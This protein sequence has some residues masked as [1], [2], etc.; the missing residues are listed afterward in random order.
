MHFCY[1]AM[2]SFQNYYFEEILLGNPK[3]YGGNYAYPIK[4]LV[5]TGLIP[6]SFVVHDLY[7]HNDGV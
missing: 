5:S 4:D 6:Y 2:N 1:I 7:H 3:N